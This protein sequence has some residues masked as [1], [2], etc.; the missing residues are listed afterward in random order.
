MHEQGIVGCA[1]CPSA[2]VG[3]ISSVREV[4]LAAAPRPKAWRCRNGGVARGFGEQPVAV[5]CG[6]PE[7]QVLVCSS[8]AS[9][10]HN[11]PATMPF[12]IHASVPGL[13]LIHI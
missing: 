10:L 3:C 7:H 12:G 8:R 13:S 4:V 1:P 9:R 2:L 11:G 5:R 6:R